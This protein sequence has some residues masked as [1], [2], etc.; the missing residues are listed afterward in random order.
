[1][2]YCEV[3]V[4]VM[5]TGLVEEGERRAEQYWPD[6]DPWQVTDIQAEY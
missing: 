5:L 2:L 4:V 1:M 3:R 6:S